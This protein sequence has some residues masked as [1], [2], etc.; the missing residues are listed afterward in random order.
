MPLSDEQKIHIAKETA[1]VLHASMSGVHPEIQ[2]EAVLLLV[3]AQFIA[4]VKS[5][6]RL[7]LFNSVMSKMKAE[8]KDHLKEEARNGKA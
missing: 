4:T 2:L 3:K 5:T 8:I 1:K 7:S 6:H